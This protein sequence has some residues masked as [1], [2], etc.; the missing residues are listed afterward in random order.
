MSLRVIRTNPYIGTKILNYSFYASE[1]NDMEIGRLPRHNG[2]LGFFNHSFKL[3]KKNANQ[4]RSESES[5]S[6]S[7]ENS[8]ILD[9]VDDFE[10]L[11]DD[12]N[13]MIISDILSNIIKRIEQKIIMRC[14]YISREAFVRLGKLMMNKKKSN[15][16]L[17]KNTLDFHNILYSNY[18]NI[19][20][21]NGLQVDS[22]SS[23]EYVSIEND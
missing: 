9:D 16:I 6:E 21:S 3:I 23:S 20:K 15:H 10:E 8:F 13:T 19:N 4:N 22:S 11:N 12:E 5:K 2:I 7:T 1:E 17:T 18:Y 14:K